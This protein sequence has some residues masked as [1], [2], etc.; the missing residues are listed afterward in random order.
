LEPVNYEGWRVVVDEQEGRKGWVL[1]RQSLHDPLL[2]RHARIQ[3][4][5]ILQKTPF[6]AWIGF[7]IHDGLILS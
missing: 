7:Y 4:K 5:Q 6:D 3:G 1:L 2:V